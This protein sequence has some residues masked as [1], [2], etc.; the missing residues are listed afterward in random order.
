MH[1]TFFFLYLQ[2]FSFVYILIF[3]ISKEKS[4]F[5]S[6]KK[7]K[8][9][10]TPATCKG[11]A[12]NSGWIRP[13]HLTSE[14]DSVVNRVGETVWFVQKSFLV[15]LGSSQSHHQ[16]TFLEHPDT[17]CNRFEILTSGGS[18]LLEWTPFPPHFVSVNKVL[19]AW[20]SSKTC[21]PCPPHPQTVCHLESG[22]WFPCVHVLFL[23]LLRI[24]NI[25]S[26]HPCFSQY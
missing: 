17:L 2:N 1:K 7:K 23:T 18:L 3:T 6:K 4:Y 21:S 15:T 12:K 13:G 25:L 22:L 9:N 14:L 20:V 19:N 10:Q 8:N 24:S 5:Y 26:S 11:S 16:G